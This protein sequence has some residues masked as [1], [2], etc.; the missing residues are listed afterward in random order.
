MVTPM[1]KPTI[2]VVI[3]IALAVHGCSPPSQPANFTMDDIEIT[4]AVIRWLAASDH[5]CANVKLPAT[6]LTPTIR[7]CAYQEASHLLPSC[8]PDSDERVI[9]ASD[10]HALMP[11]RVGVALLERNP[12]AVSL[13]AL[14]G[15]DIDV[16]P[17]STWLPDN[18]PALVFSRPA[19]AG[20]DAS[21]IYAWHIFSSVSHCG[22]L[23]RLQRRPTGWYVYSQQL[24][25]VNGN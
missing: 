22:W 24:G 15:A 7:S 20:R 4:R 1:R 5:L 8:I 19:Y 13:Q 2:A 17:S 12:I 3:S 9:R 25:Y 10:G 18:A 16:A 21:T 6:V 23:F 11:W 14:S